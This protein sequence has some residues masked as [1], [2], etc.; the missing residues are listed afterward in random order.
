MAA[1]SDKIERYQQAILDL[2]TEHQTGFQTY[3][4]G[5]YEDWAVVDKEHRHYQLVSTGWQNGRHFLDIV[6]HLS[7]KPDGKVWIQANNSDILVAR[8]LVDKGVPKSDIV[9]GFHAEKLRHLTD[10]AVA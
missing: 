8:E 4:W 7:I 5:T 9:L 1:M 6:F 3:S 2:L 10:Y